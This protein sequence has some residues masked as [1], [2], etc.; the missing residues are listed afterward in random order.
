MIL[1]E[2]RPTLVVLPVHPRRFPDEYTRSCLVG[3][4]FQAATDILIKIIVYPTWYHR[5][6]PSHP[7]IIFEP[8]YLQ[9][10]LLTVMILSLTFHSGCDYAQVLW[11]KVRHRAWFVF[12]RNL[13]CDAQFC[14][15]EVIYEIFGALLVL[16]V[17]HTFLTVCTLC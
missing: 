7:S 4:C 16:G 15:R 9:C 2:F 5:R 10:L 11:H 17:P 14:K 12:G 6:F 3:Q 13:I 8:R 1:I